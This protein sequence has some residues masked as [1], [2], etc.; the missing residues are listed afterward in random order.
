MA[1]LNSIMSG[2]YFKPRVG[3][4]R[5]P[6]MASKRNAIYFSSRIRPESSILKNIL[7]R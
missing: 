2:L 5:N 6:T 3:F 1:D 7:Y 4:Q